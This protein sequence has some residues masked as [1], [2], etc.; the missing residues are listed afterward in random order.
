MQA[1]FDMFNSR[2]NEINLYF[3]AI[4]EL[5]NY[6]VEGLSEKNNLNDEFIKILKAQSILMIYNLIESTVMGGI[7]V[8]YDKIKREKL[9]YKDINKKL[10]EI[11][12]SYKF[13][14]VYDQNSHFQSYKNKAF[15]IINAILSEKV[16]ELNRKATAI[17]GNLDAQ[18]IRNI[19][20]DHGIEFY[21]AQECQGG[22]ILENVKERRNDL[23][24][25]TISFAECGRDYTIEQLTDIKDKT[26]LFL[27]GL[28]DGMK[29]YYD[30]QKYKI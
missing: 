9:K 13:M 29:N 6:K 27:E 15:E 20:D 2:K 25:G 28:L 5:D 22:V 19:C 26:V 24:H 7:L 1:I 16:I 3:N 14:E 8:I 21:P 12:I 18:Q 17:S 4:K 23:A 30:A 10:K 11:W